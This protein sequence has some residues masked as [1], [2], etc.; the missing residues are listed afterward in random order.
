M[1]Q[2][3][4]SPAVL[5][6]DIY[7]VGAAYRMYGCKLQKQAEDIRGQGFRGLRGKMMVMKSKAWSGAE[8]TRSLQG[9]QDKQRQFGDHLDGGVWG[10]TEEEN[11]AW[12]WSPRRKCD[13]ATC[14]VSVWLGHIWKATRV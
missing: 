2:L 4:T 11:A 5:S 6:L 9:C 3:I 13:G 14:R 7:N 12:E 1:K 10:V 8:R